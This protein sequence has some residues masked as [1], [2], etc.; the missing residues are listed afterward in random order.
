MTICVNIQN[1]QKFHDEGVKMGEKIQFMKRCYLREKNK[2]RTYRR[3][4][5]VVHR[6]SYAV[7]YKN[8]VMSITAEN[9]SPGP[10]LRRDCVGYTMMQPLLYT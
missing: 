6:N 2:E 10:K 4:D 5:I 7:L 8:N 3:T 1:T 9:M